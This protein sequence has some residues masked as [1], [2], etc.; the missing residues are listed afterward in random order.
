MNIIF[1]TKNLVFNS[2]IKYPDLMVK[3]C[4]TTFI[5]G[6]SGSG[7]T[8][9]LKLFTSM[10]DISNGDIFYKG[11]SIKDID[12]IKLRRN[13]LLVGQEVFLFQESIRSNFNQFYEY[14][15]KDFI[16]DVRMQK[17]LE[18][19]MANFELDK[20]CSNLS[21]GERAR[22]YLAIFMSLEPEVIMLD[23]P[24]AA[25]DKETAG[26]VLNN[27]KKYCETNKK[28]LVVV[29]HD[30]DITNKYADEI[31]DLKEGVIHE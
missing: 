17:Y 1:S 13:V 14:L 9:L 8:T 23:E 15:D 25:L 31:I 11:V 19:T 27:V 10:N 21:G 5:K 29:S 12:T 3:E 7:K 20:E 24:T 22:V 6:P 2:M 26:K 4:I 30:E 16:D 28:T 18:I